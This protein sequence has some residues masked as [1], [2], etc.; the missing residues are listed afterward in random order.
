[1]TKDPV[2]KMTLD[3]EKAPFKYEYKGATYYFCGI[4]CMERFEK[5]PEKYLTGEKVDWIKGE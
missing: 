3:E 1:M 2:C 4:G 5:D